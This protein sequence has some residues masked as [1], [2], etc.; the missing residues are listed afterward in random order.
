PPLVRRSGRSHLQTPG[1]RLVRDL[2]RPT[3]PG[4]AEVPDVHQLGPADPAPGHQRLG[5]VG[6]KRARRPRPPRPTSGGWT[7]PNSANRG[8]RSWMNASSGVD[9]GS[10]FAATMS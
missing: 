5:D 3:L 2:V 7:W 9:P 10:N 1:R 6:D 8:W 4:G